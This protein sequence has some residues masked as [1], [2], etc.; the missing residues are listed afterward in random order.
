MK[1][2][3]DRTVQPVIDYGCSVWYNS[4]CKNLE[5]LQK[6]QNYAARIIPGNVDYINVRS[7]LLIRSLKWMTISERCDIKAI[8]GLVPNY[9]SDSIIMACEAHDRDTRLPDSR[10]TYTEP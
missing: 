5:K 7:V 9:L 10:C 3:Y 1:L 4:T 8:N 6:V 2:I